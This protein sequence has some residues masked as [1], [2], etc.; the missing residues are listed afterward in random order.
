MGNQPTDKERKFHKHPSKKITNSN[1]NAEDIVMADGANNE[2]FMRRLDN[3]PDMA[4]T[5]SMED[6]INMVIHQMEKFRHPKE[7][8]TDTTSEEN[9]ETVIDVHTYQ[10]KI[11]M[12]DERK[13]KKLK[14]STKVDK[15]DVNSPTG[16]DVYEQ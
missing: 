11:A 16:S 14:K 1:D 15:K 12:S 9:S 2:D 8:Q 13:S 4:V 7:E 3:K 5:M 6:R 10:S